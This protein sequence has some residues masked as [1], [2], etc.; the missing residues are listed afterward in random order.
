[1][2]ACR[3][4]NDCFTC[5][6]PDCIDGHKTPEERMAIL[7]CVPVESITYDIS[8]DAV[9]CNCGCRMEVSLKALNGLQNAQEWRVYKNLH[10]A[11]K[12]KSK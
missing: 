6:Y 3:F 5:P 7:L 8:V 4:H 2:N 9:A 12:A 10:E 11:L 1:M